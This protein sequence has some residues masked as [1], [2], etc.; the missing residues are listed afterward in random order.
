MAERRS[1][2]RAIK[3]K[4]PELVGGRR[5]IIGI[6]DYPKPYRQR[7]PQTDSYGGLSDRRREHSIDRS[8]DKYYENYIHI[9]V[10]PV[11]RTLVWQKSQAL[12]S[13]SL[14]TR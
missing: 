1:S 9:Y 3:P 6:S 7:D 5:K 2:K 4:L 12:S 10:I 11:K 14:T 8:R 13:N